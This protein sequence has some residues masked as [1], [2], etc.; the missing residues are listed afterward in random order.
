MLRLKA[1]ILLGVFLLSTV[2]STASAHFCDGELTEISVFTVASCEHEEIEEEEV[3]PS[4]CHMNCCSSE[5]EEKSQTEGDDDCCDTEEIEF[6][7]VDFTEVQFEQFAIVS[8]FVPSIAQ[9]LSEV[10]DAESQEVSESHYE[11]PLLYEQDIQSV[12]QV[13]QI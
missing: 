3:E 9:F 11:P 1:C 6:N 12:V 4:S 13:Y 5:K 7:Y 10:L 2:G 8:F